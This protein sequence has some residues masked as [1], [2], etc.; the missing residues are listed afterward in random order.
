MIKLPVINQ[1]YLLDSESKFLLL[2][3]ILEISKN[4][5]KS[6][7]DKFKFEVS[8]KECKSTFQK[9]SKELTL[10]INSEEREDFTNKL[11]SVWNSILVYK[12]ILNP[13]KELLELNNI[14]TEKFPLS[15]EQ[16][17]KIRDNL[18]HG[19][20]NQNLDE[21]L[22]ANKLLFIIDGILILN[23]MDI[24]EWSLENSI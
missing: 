22:L 18:T 5:T 11:N 10:M 21:L 16:I 14:D 9:I 20:S 13:I 3:N 7:R 17:K 2:Y 19:S 4:Q 23:L 24:S 6:I 8:K 1:A 12:P 15:I